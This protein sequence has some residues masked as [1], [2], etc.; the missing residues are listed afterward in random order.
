[1]AC[2]VTLHLFILHIV[3]FIVPQSEEWPFSW[4][5]EEMFRNLFNPSWEVSPETV[6]YLSLCLFVCLFVCSSVS[7]FI[8]SVCS[9]LCCWFVSCVCLLP[10]CL[11]LASLYSHD[12]VPDR[13]IFL[14]SEIELCHVDTVLR[15]PFFFLTQVRHGAATALR[16]IIKLHGETAGIS[17]Y[18]HPDKVVSP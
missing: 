16:E 3:D 14:L 15:L 8:F 5:C 7:V 11:L 6:T 2:I 18:T 17:V 1:M 13:G 9:F 10:V 12:L 4:F